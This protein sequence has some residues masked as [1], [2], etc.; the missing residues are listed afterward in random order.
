L[1]S[2][3]SIQFVAKAPGFSQWVAKVMTHDY[4]KHCPSWEEEIH[5]M[6][7]IA[8]V[9]FLQYWRDAANAAAVAAEKHIVTSLSL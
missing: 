2:R 3:Y 8:V 7:S 9:F 6:Y 4:R 5:R 1:V